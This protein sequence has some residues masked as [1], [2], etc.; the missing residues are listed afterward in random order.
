MIYYIKLLLH[1][2]TEYIFELY[3]Y[4]D[5]FNIPVD[6]ITNKIYKLPNIIIKDFS[7]ERAILYVNKYIK[8]NYPNIQEKIKFKI[9][10]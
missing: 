6:V 4:L 2:K 10:N 8:T 7:E 3:I 5:V 9:I 1:I